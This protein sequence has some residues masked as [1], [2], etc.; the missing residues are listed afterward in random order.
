[1][2]LK[3][4]WFTTNKKDSSSL[5]VLIILV[6]IAGVITMS[7]EFS[8]SRLLIPVFGSS[9]YTWGSLIGVILAGLS[10]GYH[11]G[12]RLADKDPSYEKFCSIIFS[13]GLYIFFVPFISPSII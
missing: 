1:V 6:F 9:I 13:A 8:A 4:L 3:K 5:F 11:I 12:G 7:L 2:V 10:L